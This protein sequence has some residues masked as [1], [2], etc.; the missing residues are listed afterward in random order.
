MGLLILVVSCQRARAIRRVQAEA[1]ARLRAPAVPLA[2]VRVFP[3]GENLI[4]HPV[5]PMGQT[6][7]AESSKAAVTAPPIALGGGETLPGYSVRDMQN[8]NV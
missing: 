5:G 1:A 3:V 7:S 6:V 2:V 8:R 4:F